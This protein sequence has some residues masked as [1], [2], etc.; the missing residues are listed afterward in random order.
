M[1]ATSAS[2]R[3]E[4]SCA[5]FSSPDLRFEKVTCRLM[6]FSILLSCTFPLPILS[7][8]PTVEQEEDR[9]RSEKTSGGG[10]DYVVV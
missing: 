7:P 5:F 2:H 6:L 3:T 1:R 4:I 9:G 8:S 10:G